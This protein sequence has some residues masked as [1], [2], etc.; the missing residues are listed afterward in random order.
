MTKVKIVSMLAYTVMVD[1]EERIMLGID[2]VPLMY[3]SE[4]AL[5]DSGIPKLVQEWSNSSGQTFT[6]RL[7]S[8]VTTQETIE[9]MK[10]MLTM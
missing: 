9:P 5:K 1:N 8:E 4:K 3:L 2:G 6:L 7:F 10:T